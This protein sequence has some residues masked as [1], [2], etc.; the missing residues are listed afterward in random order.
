MGRRNSLG[1]YGLNRD[2]VTQDDYDVGDEIRVKLATVELWVEV[3]GKSDSIDDDPDRN[4]AGWTGT[5]VEVVDAMYPESNGNTPG[6]DM[7]GRVS[8]VKEVR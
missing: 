3:D 5:V 6:T 2:T 4:E 8:Q 1:G 7:W